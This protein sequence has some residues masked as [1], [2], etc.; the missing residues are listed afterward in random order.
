LAT[1]C[2]RRKPWRR[3]V[4]GRRIAPRI[5][6]ERIPSRMSGSSRRPASDAALAARGGGT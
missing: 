6:G 3:T 2:R 4:D 5:S 1:S